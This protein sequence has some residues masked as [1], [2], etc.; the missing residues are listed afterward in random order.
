MYYVIYLILRKIYLTAKDRVEHRTV[1]AN[2]LDS[3]T[4][5]KTIPSL[6]FKDSSMQDVLKNAPKLYPEDKFLS[7]IVKNPECYNKFELHKGILW[8]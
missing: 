5:E 1:K 8:T 2:N 6:K 4:G 7:H 3:Q